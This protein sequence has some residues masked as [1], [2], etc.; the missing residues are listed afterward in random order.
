[1]PG[2]TPVFPNPNNLTENSSYAVEADALWEANKTGPYSMRVN[3]AAFL[4]LSVITD[5]WDAMADKILAQADDPGAYLPAGVHPTVAAGYAEQLR[6]LARQY[7]SPRSAVYELP[8]SGNATM[9][10]IFVKP[11]SRGTVHISPDDDG[12]D[13]SGRGDA[14]PLV[15]YRTLSNPLDL[16]TA[17]A[18]FRFVRQFVGSGA[19]AETFHPKETAPGPDVASEEEIRAWIAR[20]GQP[21]NGHSTGT[22]RIGPRELGGVLAP[23]L[24]VHGVRGLSVA[25]CSV[26][27]LV[28]GTHTS[29]TA[30]AIAEKVSFIPR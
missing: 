1:V 3:T 4:P 7:A 14:E 24:T 12:V 10:P 23:D 6:T 8:F 2:G 25:D 21:S 26:M 13:P 17:V 11:L 28:P 30:Y 29:S 5:E 15:D 27:P 20:D 22:A 19:M 16:D 18:M 9:V